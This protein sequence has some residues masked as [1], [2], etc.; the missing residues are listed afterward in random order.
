MIVLIGE[1]DKT[2]TLFNQV[3]EDALEES[4]GLD[5]HA[6]PVSRETVKAIEHPQMFDRFSPNN[7]DS[8]FLRCPDIL[9]LGT[10]KTLG[11]LFSPPI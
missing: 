11:C 8:V 9:S 5:G 10:M 4:P 3:A 6:M 2:T 7:L 1:Q